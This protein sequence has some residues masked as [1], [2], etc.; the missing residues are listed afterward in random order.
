MGHI[1]SADWLGSLVFGAGGIAAAGA[2]VVGWFSGLPVV[3]QV[4]FT[5]SGGGA[6]TLLLAKVIVWW[7]ERKRLRVVVRIGHVESRLST[8]ANHEAFIRLVE[9]LICSYEPR[10]IRLELLARWKWN[11]GMDYTEKGWAIS[12]NGITDKDRLILSSAQ[13][14]FESGEIRFLANTHR[15][16]D[17]GVS[18]RFPEATA[19]VV[20]QDMITGKEYEKELAPSSGGW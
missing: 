8:S 12:A 20:V 4:S 6:L 16:K 14:V 3:L 10:P 13:P 15:A 7:R 19:F 18:G 2:A 11:D 17:R 9:V 5:V 1:S